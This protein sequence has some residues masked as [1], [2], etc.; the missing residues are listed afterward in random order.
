MYE[1]FKYTLCAV[2]IGSWLTVWAGCFYYALFKLR[3]STDCEACFLD[4]SSTETGEKSRAF[5]AD[6]SDSWT[7]AA[8]EEQI[9]RVEQP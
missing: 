2:L 3:Y 1:I 5:E 6:N 9:R 8:L 4:G 7:I